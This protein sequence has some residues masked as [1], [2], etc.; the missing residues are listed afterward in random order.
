MVSLSH[1]LASMSDDD[2]MALVGPAAWANGLRLARGGAVRE[3]SWSED[4]EWAE[5]RVKERGKVVLPS[6]RQLFSMPLLV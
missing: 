2:M 5:A 3:F 6:L 4:G 1:T